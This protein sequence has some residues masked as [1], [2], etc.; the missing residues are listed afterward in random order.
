MRP[1]SWCGYSVAALV[2]G[3]IPVGAGLL[4]IVL[5][6]IGINRTK[7][8]R[9]RGRVHGRVNI[10]VVV[11]RRCQQASYKLDPVRVGAGIVHNLCDVSGAGSRGKV[12]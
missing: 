10:D 8:G 12:V 7:A 9:Q 6:A 2:V 4:G 5:G 11:F 1:G 3:I